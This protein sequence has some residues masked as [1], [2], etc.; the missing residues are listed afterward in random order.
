MRQI[1]NRVDKGDFVF[2]AFDCHILAVHD[3]DAGE[4]EWT[5]KSFGQ[6]KVV[7]QSFNLFA[8]FEE[9]LLA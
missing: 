1:I 4:P 5:A 3:Q 6:L 2:V 7:W 8:D 9:Y